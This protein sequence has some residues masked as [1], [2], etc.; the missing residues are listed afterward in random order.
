MAEILV[1]SA[2]LRDW[3]KNSGGKERTANLIEALDGHNVTF[4]SFAWDPNGFEKQISENIYQIQPGISVTA[5]KQYKKLIRSIAQVNY[6]ACFEILK[7]ELI[8]FTKKA[9]ELAKKSDLVIVDHMS[10]S[11]LIYDLGDVPIIY[12]SH[13]AEIIMA[14]Q[15]YPNDSKIIKLVEQVEKKIINDSVAVTYCSKKDIVE[16]ED[17]YGKINK[18]FYVPNGTDMQEKIKAETRMKSKNIIFVGSGHPPNVEA[19]KKLIPLAKNMPDYNFVIIGNSGNGLSEQNYTSNLKVLGQVSDDKLHELFKT[20][21]AFINPMDSGSGTHLKMMKAL[22][23]GIPIITSTV[24]ARGFSDKEIKDTMLIANSEKEMIK[25]IQMLQNKQTY[26]NLCNNGYTHSKTY[27][28]H[29]IKKDYLIFINSFIK[30]KTKDNIQL[31]N[32][33]KEKILVCSS[34]RNEAMHID[35]FHKRLQSM[36]KNFP[37]YEFYISLYENDSDDGTKQK[38]L[39]KDWTMFSGISILS[40]N[41][42][43]KDYGPVKDA[44]RVKNL[45]IARNKVIRGGNFI[46]LCDYVLMIDSDIA[47]DIPAVKKIL[48]FKDIEPNFDIVSA[49]SIR[50]GQLYDQWATRDGAEYDP[51]MKVLFQEYRKEPYKKYYATSNGFCL[52]RAQPFKNGVVYDYINK[53]TK[54]ADC[55]MVVVCQ[56]FHAKGYKNIY[57]VHDAEVYHEHY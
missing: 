25:S 16:L 56:N 22:S 7:N 37:Q 30:E 19:A 36:V 35:K 41:I 46:D 39:T 6:D 28:W 53:V 45:A 5:I 18:S 8:L 51:N 50:R 57:I 42:K 26:K 3:N 20:S 40:E 11:P 10:V 1:I 21:F 9:K 17:Y 52:Y 4:L 43:T 49:A 12:N 33:Q 15:L 47:F 38:L 24:G 13:N 48:E 32:K 44:D 27:D 23:Y 31:N 54:E 2:N 14:K 34:I 55:E 29:N